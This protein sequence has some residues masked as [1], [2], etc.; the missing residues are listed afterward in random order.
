MRHM[1]YFGE[2]RQAPYEPLE[3]PYPPGTDRTKPLPPAPFAGQH[4]RE[5]LAAL[6]RSQGQIAALEAGGVVVQRT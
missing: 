6:G 4:T 3:A 1:G 2:L 5:I